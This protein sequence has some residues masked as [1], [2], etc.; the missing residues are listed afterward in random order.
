VPPDRQGHDGFND[1]GHDRALSFCLKNQMFNEALV[2]WTKAAG[3]G[4]VPEPETFGLTLKQADGIEER[5]AAAFEAA[6]ETTQKRL[7]E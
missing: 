1:A 6:F 2:A 4:P 7:A 3:Q 5:G